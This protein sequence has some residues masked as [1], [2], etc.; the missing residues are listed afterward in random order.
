M[1]LAPADVCR[2]NIFY[3][4]GAI[5]HT[6]AFTIIINVRTAAAFINVI[7]VKKIQKIRRDAHCRSTREC[8]IS[9]SRRFPLTRRVHALVINTDNFLVYFFIFFS[10]FAP[11]GANITQRCAPNGNISAGP[12]GNNDAL[13]RQLK[14]HCHSRARPRENIFFCRPGN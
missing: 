7:C 1:I 13:Y 3:R 5:T 4:D 6:L 10:L 2:Q 8:S 9:H 14:K 12:V 11:R